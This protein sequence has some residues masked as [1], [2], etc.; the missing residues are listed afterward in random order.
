[1]KK[2]ELRKH[3]I[4]QS[5][6]V[7]LQLADFCYDIIGQSLIVQLKR[8]DDKL[9]LIV[10]TV[11]AQLKAGLSNSAF[12]LKCQICVPSKVRITEFL[13]KENEG[14]CNKEEKV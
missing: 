6:T 4:G 2:I 12:S 14:L 5:L 3:S 8:L 11:F 1:M 9:N 7:Q 10:Q 13:H